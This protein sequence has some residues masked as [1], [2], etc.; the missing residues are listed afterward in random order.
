MKSYI[1][2]PKSV[3][4]SEILEKQ[5]AFASSKYHHIFIKNK[6]GKT[7]EDLRE[8]SFLG[9]NPVQV[10]VKSDFKMLKISSSEEQF[11]KTNLSEVASTKPFSYKL[12]NGNWIFFATRGSVQKI[13]FLN[14]KNNENIIH[15]NNMYAVK[16]NNTLLFYCL[17]FLKS[18][19]LVDYAKTVSHGGTISEFLPHQILNFKIPFPTI[20]NNKNPE[21]V[22][23]FASLV[24]Q[25]I[26]DKEEQIKLKNNQIDE[27]I[28]KELKE[29]Q[30]AESFSYGYPRISEIK[31]ETRLDTG[32]YEREFKEIDFLIRNYKDGYF[33]IPLDKFKSGSTPKI[34]IFDPQNKKYKW[35]TPTLITD[36]GN[37]QPST[38]IN[39]DTKNNLSKDCILI[40]NRTSKGKKGEYVGIT[41]FYEVET[42][43]LGQHNQGLYQI[44]DYSKTEKL[45][46]TCLLNSKTYRKL[47]GCVAIGSKMKEMKSYDFAFLKFPSFSEKKQQEVSNLYYSP[48]EKNINLTLEN[49]LEKEKTRN[50]EAGIFQ[51]NM[52]IFSL[53][54]QLEDLVHKIVM[55]EPIEIRLEY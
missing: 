28:E 19:L 53:R 54:E 3:R 30:K 40:I 36:E 35:V 2:K 12:E 41:C 31:E 48:I 33:Q 46:I 15:S 27:L 37:Y 42:L 26:I 24:V 29:N 43:G 18:K 14:I 34:R 32:I 13:S 1:I 52:E 23:E 55:E 45:F 50:A 4:K 5:Y 11:F 9:K 51:L 17:A 8:E 21:K 20:A 10:T 49:Y 22:E 38:T 7:I 25:N 16:I 44:K 39:M 6:N 47:C